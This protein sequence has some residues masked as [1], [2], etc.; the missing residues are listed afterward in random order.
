MDYLDD[1]LRTRSN[2]QNYYPERKYG[3][4]LRAFA[5]E[6][7]LDV[8]FRHYTSDDFSDEWAWWG[9]FRLT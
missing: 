2:D 8:P 3:D 4:T 1:W 5:D 9:R 7:G 6:Y